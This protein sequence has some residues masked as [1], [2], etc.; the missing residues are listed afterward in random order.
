V[1]NCAGRADSFATDFQEC[2][3][4]GRDRRT[5]LHDVRRAHPMRSFTGKGLYAVRTRGR[6]SS[7]TAVAVITRNRQRVPRRETSRDK[8]EPVGRDSDGLVNQEDS[9]TWIV[10]IALA[11]G[12]F[13]LV[14]ARRH[15]NAA[16]G[17]G[18]Q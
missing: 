15:R 10:I 3:V 17:T 5:V 13:G 6:P 1:Y 8:V 18:Q 14:K 7:G 2:G 11:V 9:M 16:A 4:A 12:A